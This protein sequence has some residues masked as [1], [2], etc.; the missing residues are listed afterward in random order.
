MEEDSKELANAGSFGAS[1]HFHSH[2]PMPT[3]DFVSIM[4]EMLRDI[5]KSTTKPGSPIMGHI[6]AFIT[7]PQGFLK[8]NLIDMDLGVEQTTTIKGASVK[9]GEIKVMA[10][11]MGVPDHQVQKA[12]GESIKP[13]AKHFELEL[14]EHEDHHEHDHG[15]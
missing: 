6:K 7:T 11:L 14:E 1:L 9:E 15:H 13:L 3:D 5:G 2:H 4:S 12:I 8:L 10:A